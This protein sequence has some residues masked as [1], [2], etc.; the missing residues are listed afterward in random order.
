MRGFLLA[1]QAN[2]FGGNHITLFALIT[3]LGCLT[4]GDTLVADT[5]ILMKKIT[6]II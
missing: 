1:L 5:S 6:R 3:T 4:M 2:G